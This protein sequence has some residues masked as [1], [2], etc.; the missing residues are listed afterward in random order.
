M[1]IT[2]F[3]LKVEITMKLP[4]EIPFQG[5][6]PTLNNDQLQLLLL[7]K[8]K[9]GFY[10]LD[11]ALVVFDQMLHLKP[12]PN[13]IDFAQLLAALVKTKQYA[14]AVSIYRD[15]CLKTVPLDVVTFNTVINCFCHLN[16]V[17]YAFSLLAA[18]IKHGFLPNVVTYTTLIHPDV[19]TYTTIID[20]LCKS[21]HPSVAVKLFRY[22]EKKGCKPDTVTYSTIIDCLCKCR[23]V[24]QA[25]GLFRQMTAKGIMPDV[26]TYSSLIQGLCDF[27]RWH[28][29]NGLLREMNTSNI[30][31]DLHM[32]NI[33]VDAY[34]KEGMI[35][36]AEYVIELMIQRGH[37][38]DVVTYNS[39]MDGYCL[40]GEVD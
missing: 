10:K 7:E 28:D 3:K 5:L 16:H 21:G 11:D 8:S 34:G 15:L 18:I 12:L 25:L 33:L 27:N 29:T 17:D 35:E 22:M 20:G 14:V 2:L 38:P 26:I 19:V 9:T 39:L 40:R 13:V 24:D 31:H 30:S 32:F 6:T 1:K 37:F 4:Q 23:L 36:D